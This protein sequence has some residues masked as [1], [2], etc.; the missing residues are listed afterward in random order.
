MEVIQYLKEER[1]PRRRLPLPL[2]EFELRDNVLYHLRH[3]P[4]GLVKQLVIPR[5]L[6]SVA[7]EHTH[8]APTA[9]H[10][11][12]FRTYHR[13][14]DMYYFPN[15]LASTKDFVKCCGPCQRRKGAQYRN[16]PL[17]RYPDVVIPL[18]RVSVDLLQVAPSSRHFKYIF[19]AIDHCTRY[20]TLVP[21]KTKT[22]SEVAKALINKLI[23][24]LGPPQVIQSDN[25][26]EFRNEDWASVCQ[27]IKAKTQ[28]TIAYHPQSNG[29]V[30]RTNRIVKDSLACSCEADPNR[31]D[32]SVPYVQFALNTAIHRS[33]MNQ[34]LH[35]LTGS[36]PNYPIG[37]TNQVEL[38]DGV[39]A[40]F[41]R[42]LEEARQAA[43]HASHSAQD[44]WARHYNKK[45]RHRFEPEVG[46]LV[47]VKHHPRAAAS[48]RYVLRPRW[49]GPFRLVK[50]LGPV[51][52]LAK[53][54]ADP[55][56]EKIVHTNQMKPYHLYGELDLPEYPDDDGLALD[57]P[58]FLDDL[59]VPEEPPEEGLRGPDEM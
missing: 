11:G 28:F 55:D 22:A 32:E 24:V 56:M 47:L 52:W 38:A 59:A 45:I 39:A 40:D 6:R 34:P 49:V 16:T 5:E 50:C 20:I 53:P 41:H 4:E 29:M 27:I 57:P 23:L 19:T 31:W 21:L 58:Q 37:L 36:L 3:L 44:G 1:V 51:S 18:Q 43:L 7:L 14:R 8:S 46:A 25:G 10:P 26:R 35:L 15:M 13:L 30:E 48:P 42:R 12:V 33:I 17:R 2:G 9:A 54:L